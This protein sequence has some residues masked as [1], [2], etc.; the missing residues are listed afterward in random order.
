LPPV[1]QPDCVFR[2]RRTQMHVAL[3]RRQVCVAGQLLDGPRRRALH[4]QVRT[5][6]VP[7]DMDALLDTRDAL[8]AADGSNHAMRVID[9]PSG[10]HS[11]RSDRRCRVA[12][13]A[14]D[15]RCVIGN[16][17][18]RPPFGTVTYPSHSD[19]CT[20]NR[21][22]ADA[23]WKSPTPAEAGTPWRERPLLWPRARSQTRSDLVVVHATVLRSSTLA[24]RGELVRT[25]KSVARHALH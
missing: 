12:L 11:T 6:R 8:G 25:S 2:C 17:R 9:D 22:A 1:E 5:E 14:A 4:R 7:Q 3:R 15:S 18:K 20:V 24:D 19:R 21:R 10:K 13:S 23:I 16:C